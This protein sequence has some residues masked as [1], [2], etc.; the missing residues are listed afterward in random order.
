M[1]PFLKL[2]QS[3]VAGLIIKKRS[4]D[5]PEAPEEPKEDYSIEDCAKELI[6]AIHAKSE[7]SVIAALKDIFQKLE[8]EPHEEGEHINPHSYDAQNEKAAD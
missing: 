6:N 4:A 1:L 7:S 8:K 3:P 5:Q 2:K